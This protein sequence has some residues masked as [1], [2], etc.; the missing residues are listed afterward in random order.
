MADDPP[1]YR[2]WKGKPQSVPNFYG[3][4]LSALRELGRFSRDDIGEGTGLPYKAG[5]EELIGDWRRRWA[6][7]E[8]EYP[9]AYPHFASE[10]P[11]DALERLDRAHDL[12]F[13]V[14]SSRGMHRNELG[15]DSGFS[16]LELRKAMGQDYSPTV[17]HRM[18]RHSGLG[19]RLVSPAAAHFGV[20]KDR[21][22]IPLLINAH[23]NST[24]VTTDTEANVPYDLA[25]R[26]QHQGMMQEK[27]MDYVFDKRDPISQ[28]TRMRQWLLDNGYTALLYPNEAEGAP[29]TDT[30]QHRVMSTMGVRAGSYLNNMPFYARS[31][32]MADIPNP[33]MVSLDPSN[34]RHQMADF[35]PK[36]AKKIGY[37]LAVPLA[38]GMAGLKYLQGNKAEAAEV[39]GNDF[40]TKR[41]D[42]D[43]IEAGNIDL[44]NRPSV[45]IGDGRRA[46]VRTTGFNFGGKEVNLPTVSDDGRLLSNEEAIEQYKR[47]GRHLGVYKTPEGAARAAEALHLDQ[48]AMGM[49]SPQQEY[50]LAN[51]PMYQR[52][53]RGYYPYDVED[54]GA[55][56][57]DA[58]DA[59]LDRYFPTEG[60][61]NA[62]KSTTWWEDGLSKTALDMLATP[63]D[64]VGSAM[65]RARE[66]QVERPDP[67]IEAEAAQLPD[68][69]AQELLLNEERRMQA[70]KNRR[71]ERAK[72]ARD[73][74]IPFMKRDEERGP[75]EHFLKDEVRNQ[76]RDDIIGGGIFAGVLGGGI[77]AG[78]KAYRVGKRGLAAGKKKLGEVREGIKRRYGTVLEFDEAIE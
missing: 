38:G 62:M 22:V 11:K 12:G 46:S 61:N 78:K 66:S 13:R 21:A 63:M 49:G 19:D 77:Y 74:T 68:L 26:L 17:A 8:K 33:S 41:K 71:Q 58:M 42:P 31:E 51:D 18:G 34:I 9:D 52:L 7:L 67:N 47:T 27:D 30:D 16:E 39:L 70:I 69:E 25:E 73:P 43:L 75:M 4:P 50:N 29:R 14:P 40:W 6:D 3:A 54:M 76:V 60:A 37:K 20:G 72:V 57:T 15:S 36:L 2:D 23:P 44:T 65:G 64:L 59:T 28:A 48:E 55:P 32:A 5:K 45:P 56:A 24:L 10:V 35:D 53:V 1:A